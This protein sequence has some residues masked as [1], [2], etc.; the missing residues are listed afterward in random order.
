MSDLP[1]WRGFLLLALALWSLL[2]LGARQLDPMTLLVG[3]A[4]ANGAALHLQRMLVQARDAVEYMQ[5]LLIS[6]VALACTWLWAR[7]RGGAPP[8]AWTDALQLL[9]LALLA[10][11]TLCMAFDP[12][13]RDFPLAV[14]ATPGILLA[15]AGFAGP[16]AR[17][18]GRTLAILLLAG[19]PAIAWQET[20]RNPVAVGW[21][22]LS[23]IMG[24]GL[25]RS[26][27]ACAA[28]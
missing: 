24:V 7:R 17:A 26:G 23:A 11:E 13:Y 20:L 27:R 14:F 18:R 25:L 1:R 28:P 19:I 16:D 2:A 15:H 21:I 10:I 5:Y 12:R 6:G 8:P 9:L 22:A 3:A 4:A